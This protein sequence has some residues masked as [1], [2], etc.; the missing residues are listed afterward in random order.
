MN[1]CFIE[2]DYCVFSFLFLPRYH[3]GEIYLQELQDTEESVL[4]FILEHSDCYN[5]NVLKFQQEGS[6]PHYTFAVANI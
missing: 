4:S 6:P 2:R 5:K 3:T 1:I